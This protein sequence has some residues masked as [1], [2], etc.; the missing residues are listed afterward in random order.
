[1]SNPLN[2]PIANPV[3]RYLLDKLTRIDVLRIWYDEWRESLSPV[4]CEAGEFLG[5]TLGKLNARLKIANPSS[6]ADIPRQGPLIVVANHPLGGLEGM[7]LSQQLLAVR[8]DLKVLTNELLLSF[9]EFKDLFIGVDVLNQDRQQVNS[10]GI[11]TVGK[12]LSQGGALLIFPAGTV[13]GLKL[14]R[15]RIE[16]SPWHP[17]VGRLALKYQAACVPVHVCGRNKLMFYL[18]GVVHK[19]LRMLLLP[20]AMLAKSGSIVC[21]SVGQVIEAEDIQQLGGA[22]IVT[23]YLRLCSEL[24]GRDG[25][26]SP[27][28]K[29]RAMG[30]R[31][32]AVSGGVPATELQKQLEELSPYRILEQGDFAVYCAPYDE[33]ACVMDQLATER[34]RTFRAV[35]EGTG[36]ELDNDRFDPY[37][38]HLWVWDRSAERL[39]GGYRL[40][41]VDKLTASRGI[42]C[43]YSRSLFGYDANFVRQLGKAVEVG[44]SFIAPEYQRHPR[45][46]DLLWKGIGG[47]MANNPDYHTLFGCVSISRQYSPL[48]RTLLAESFLVHYGVEGSLQHQVQ[49]SSPLRVNERPWSVELMASLSDIPIINKLLGRIDAGKSIPILIRHY[50]ALNGRFVSFT[51]NQGFNQSLDG[52]IMVDLRM[53]PGKYLNRYLGL[54]GAAEFNRRWG[55][56][57]DAA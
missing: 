8:P 40:A 9:S 51:V 31:A 11:R 32:H 12:H 18:A 7:L 2:L 28:M 10:K 3:F 16:D 56:R 6:L 38:W 50:L 43:L 41:L 17:M 39:V 48:A 47:F 25:V 15:L 54:K 14:N 44:R 35:D 49:P 4:D 46:L 20:R 34:E 21:A 37:Y 24:L 53:A 27:K 36:Q 1:M 23:Q 29:S 13:S 45:A 33:L 57:Q 30:S 26:P 42:D 52:L 5:F 19:R 22:D 55:A